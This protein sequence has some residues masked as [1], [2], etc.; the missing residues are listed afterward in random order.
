M[1]IAAP[2]R[3]QRIVDRNLAARPQHPQQ[4]QQPEEMDGDGEAHHQG[5]EGKSLDHPCGTST[6]RTVATSCRRS[7]PSFSSSKPMR[8]LIMRSTGSLP[9]W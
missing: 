5:G 3:I 1:K 4:R 7:K 6:W 9:C 2:S 8:L